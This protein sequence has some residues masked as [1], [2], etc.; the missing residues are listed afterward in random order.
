MDAASVATSAERL[1]SGLR[2][3]RLYTRNW[4]DLTGS[5][6][7]ALELLGWVISSCLTSVPHLRT[8]IFESE[9]KQQW[10]GP[11]GVQRWKL[12]TC[13]RS[14]A[15][16]QKIHCRGC[17]IFW[18]LKKTQSSFQTSQAHSRWMNMDYP[19]SY[20]QLGGQEICR[21][22]IND[23]KW[24]IKNHR[25]ASWLSYLPGAASL[26]SVERISQEC[27]WK[28]HSFMFKLCTKFKDVLHKIVA[29]GCPTRP[30]AAI[31]NIRM[32]HQTAA[33]VV[34]RTVA[35]KGFAKVQLHKFVGT[36]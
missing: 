31:K 15:Q 9:T 27:S 17:D 3:L 16:I 12:E 11:R 26:F 10:K 5:K 24:G 20:A 25:V 4:A 1:R 18:E 21:M 28:G 35:Q 32:C 29:E 34:Q 22:K 36:E 7:D 30:T 23:H 14:T 33:K 13:A 2:S 19:L 8:L 6:R